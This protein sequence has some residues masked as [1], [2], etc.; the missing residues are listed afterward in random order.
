MFRTEARDWNVQLD[1]AGIFGERWLGLQL[2]PR[3]AFINSEQFQPAN[4]G[5]RTTEQ[6][7]R[8]LGLDATR[9]E[10]VEFVQFPRTLPRGS[11]LPVK[12]A[13][14]DPES[15]IRQVL[16]LSGKLPADG[17]ISPDAVLALLD[18]PA[19]EKNRKEKKTWEAQLPVA[20]EKAGKVEVTVQLT[21]GA[22]LTSSRTAV[23][24]LVD[25]PADAG[26]GARA[27]IAGTVSEGGRAQPNLSVWLFDPQGVVRDSVTSDGEGR[28]LFKDVASGTYR[29]V[30]VKSG[31]NTRG[32]AAVQVQ[33]GQ[34]KT[35]VDV[36]MVR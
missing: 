21:N 22:G 26:K 13:G 34:K 8:P 14:F 17:K 2:D 3:A 15:G 16:F 23:V 1:T 9:P 19:P 12:V 4:G 6:I 33:E 36:K 28:F 18:D 11:L 31:S 24:Q 25:P 35:G 20:T 5:F 29:V 10:G 7:I 32:E 30:A 27:S